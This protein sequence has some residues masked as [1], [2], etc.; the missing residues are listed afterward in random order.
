[1]TTTQTTDRT[2]QVNALL[3]RLA[4]KVS[5]PT[6]VIGELCRIHRDCPAKWSRFVAG[7]QAQMNLSAEDVRAIV[8][9]VEG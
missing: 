8:E 6:A 5:N 4:G 9:Y 3:A 7:A 1:M 2:Q